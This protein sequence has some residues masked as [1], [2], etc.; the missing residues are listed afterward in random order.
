MTQILNLFKVKI[1][2]EIQDRI[3]S[4]CLKF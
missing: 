1:G 4:L 2:F 3:L